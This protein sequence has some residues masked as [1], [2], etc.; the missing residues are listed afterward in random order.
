MIDAAG[1]RGKA[2]LRGIAVQSSMKAL[3]VLGED[4]PFW[5][6]GDFAT[7]LCALLRRPVAPFGDLLRT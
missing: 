6:A 2:A 3:P 7:A 1:G 4:V 5:S